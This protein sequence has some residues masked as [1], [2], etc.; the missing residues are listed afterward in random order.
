MKASLKPKNNSPHPGSDLIKAG[1]SNAGQGAEKT[2]AHICSP[3]DE[4]NGL[5][6]SAWQFSFFPQHY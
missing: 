6:F 5:C 1:S 4:K 2:D 3:I